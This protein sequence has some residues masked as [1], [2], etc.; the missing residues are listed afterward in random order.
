MSE[1]QGRSQ[2]RVPVSPRPHKTAI[3]LAQRIVREITERKLAPATVLPPER[4]MLQEY[5]VARGTLRE[6]LRFL[7][8]QGVL[9]MKPG[10]GGGPTVNGVE[11]RSL[12]SVIA[13]LLDLSHAPFSTILEARRVLEPAMAG[14]AA[15]HV[16]ESFLNSLRA[17]LEAMEAVVDDSPSFFAENSNFHGIIARASG[18]RLFELLQGS[19][20]W[21]I[22]ASALGVRYDTR[23]RRAI[24]RAHE[25]IYR[26]LEARDGRAAEHAMRAHL[27]E[28][29]AYVQRH[30]AHVLKEPLRWDATV[31]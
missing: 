24:V 16:D 27:D 3:L 11:P 2:A 29:A 19:L 4:V 1:I 7:E 18:N 12:A 17:S 5:G 22:D 26:A 20:G 23:R 8:I 14:M 9:T 10:P 30:Y 6:A 28:F 21:I 15:A 25:E 13:L 31:L